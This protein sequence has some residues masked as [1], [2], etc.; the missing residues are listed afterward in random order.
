M[1]VSKKLGAKQVVME[2]LLDRRVSTCLLMFIVF[3][4]GRQ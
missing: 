1:K 3:A 4:R 2:S